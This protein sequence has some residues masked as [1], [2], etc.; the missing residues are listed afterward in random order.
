[1]TATLVGFRVLMM[2]L[3]SAG[4]WASSLATARWKTVQPFWDS[5]VLVA[6][7]VMRGRPP[8]LKIGSAALDSPEKAGPM[9]ATSLELPTAVV[10]SAGACD[11]S[12][13]LSNG[14]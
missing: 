9:M 11:G 2:K 5:V 4:P 10:A 1:M 6:D 14:R 13:W 12:P 8:W 7:T 3:A